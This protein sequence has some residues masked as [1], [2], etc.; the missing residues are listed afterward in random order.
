MHVNFLSAAARAKTA[1]SAD[2]RRHADARRLMFYVGIAWCRLIYLFGGSWDIQWHITVGRDSLF[3][4]PHLLAGLGFVLECGLALSLLVIESLQARWRQRPSDSVQ[5]GAWA[6][7]LPLWGMLVGY[8][9]TLVAIIADDLWHRSFGL[10]ARLWSPPHL[11]LMAAT[12]SADGWLLV[13]LATSA[14]RLGR[15]LVFRQLWSWAFVLAAA[16]LFDVVHFA[17]SEAFVVSMQQSGRYLSNALFPLLVGTVLPLPLLLTIQLAKRFRIVAPVVG[18]VILL[19]CVGLGIA[20]FGFRLLRPTSA[21]E[22]FVADNAASMVALTRSTLA[23]NSVGWVGW[24]QIW[25]FWLSA[26]PL[27]LIALLD[28]WPWAVRH[29]LIAAPI[30][31]IGLVFACLVGFQFVPTTA[32]FP[33]SILDIAVTLLVVIIGGSLMGAFGQWLGRRAALF[34]INHVKNQ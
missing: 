26:V 2:V 6:A 15:P 22:S 11:A 32:R 24:Q 20:E 12:A 7:P 1:L 30:Y 23:A 28:R 25:I 4:P 27:L 29:P 14:S 9:S 8:A 10:D 21:L 19:Q 34:G 31:S 16:Y 33:L 17:A 3:I 5:I 18:V 13:G